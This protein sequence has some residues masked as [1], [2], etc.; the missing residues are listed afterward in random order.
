MSIAFEPYFK[1]KLIDLSDNTT[2]A[3]GGG[4]NTQTL[5]ADVGFIYEI[6]KFWINIP[7]AVGST[8]NTHT[9]DVYFDASF[10]GQSRFL[11]MVSTSGNAILTLNQIFSADSSE[12]PSGSDEQFDLLNGIAK[13]Y[14]NNTN[15]LKFLYTNGLDANQTGTRTIKI[16]V[17]EYK[18]A[19]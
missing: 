3:S 18:E 11:R 7:D 16:L 17:K 8:A 10:T 13:T 2:V 4:T 9:L 1:L 14:V 12:I 5:Q 19:N 15:T 6:V